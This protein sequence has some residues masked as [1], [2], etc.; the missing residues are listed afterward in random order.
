MSF[1]FS[2][3]QLGANMMNQQIQALAAQAC[4]PA[5][6]LETQVKVKVFGIYIF[7]ALDLAFF[8]FFYSYYL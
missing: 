5:L 3:G 1:L 4:P 6:I 2:E 7:G 8:P